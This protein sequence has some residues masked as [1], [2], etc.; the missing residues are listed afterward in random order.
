MLSEPSFGIQVKRLWLSSEDSQF[1]LWIHRSAVGV[2]KIY[3]EMREWLARK[4]SKFIFS[5]KPSTQSFVDTWLVVL[6]SWTA[7]LN[8]TE[9]HTRSTFQWHTKQVLGNLVNEV[10]FARL[11]KNSFKCLLSGRSKGHWTDIPRR[12]FWR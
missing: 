8:E 9:F 7:W 2:L 11:G 4:T 12:E 6:V 3:L 1:S 5:C 10:T